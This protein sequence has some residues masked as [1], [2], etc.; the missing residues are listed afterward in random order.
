MKKKIFSLMLAC[1]LAI[2]CL[3]VLASCSTP[4]DEPWK[5]D[6]IAENVWK[7]YLSTDKF[8]L[9]NGVNTDIN[10]TYILHHVN[11]YYT[12]RGVN[13]QDN[14]KAVCDGTNTSYQQVIKGNLADEIV[15]I[16]QAEYDAKIDDVKDVVA[17]VKDNQST[18]TFYDDNGSGRYKLNLAGSEIENTVNNIK[19]QMGLTNYTIDY[20][21]AA[22]YVY[23]G[24]SIDCWNNEGQH[25]LNITF[26]KTTFSF[27]M[28]DITSA[29]TSYTIKGGPSTTDLAYAEVQIT[30]DGFYRNL[31]NQDPS[32][33][34][35][36]KLISEGTNAGKYIVYS[37]GTW[38][39]PFDKT[40]YNDTFF[41]P[42]VKCYFGNM[43]T[44][45]EYRFNDDGDLVRTTNCSLTI[46]RYVYTYS[47]IVIDL[48][49]YNQIIGVNWNVQIHDNALNADSEVYQ[50]SLMVES[51]N[52]EFPN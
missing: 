2:S 3:C 37:N 4:P 33:K 36:G 30:P 52:I 50:M 35:Y 12:V 47:N 10:D 27:F 18:F 32:A 26:P 5:Q 39:S 45:G 20:I 28:E 11:G 7:N 29:M 1:C 22:Y 15:D 31:P 21:N 24:F 49:E 41:T 42:F 6:A 40:Y 14:Y 44:T 17:F 43:L 51:V 34:L 48:N 38:S 13:Y 16:T 8:Y 23:S 25:V 46:T 9:A 19:N